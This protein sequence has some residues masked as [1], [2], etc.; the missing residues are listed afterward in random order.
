MV[1][2]KLMTLVKGKRRDHCAITLILSFSLSAGGAGL[3]CVPGAVQRGSQ[4]PQD[5]AVP[6]HPL[7]LLHCQPHL[8]R[9][10]ADQLTHGIHTFQTLFSAAICVLEPYYQAE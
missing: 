3:P 10:R 9:H 1:A 8:H 2:T 6:P 7:C 5:D 4:H